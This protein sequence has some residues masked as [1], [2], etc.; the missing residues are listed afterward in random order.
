MMQFINFLVY[1]LKICIDILK[2]KQIDINEDITYI[3]V[4]KQLMLDL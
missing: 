3:T 1:W 4:I 2:W